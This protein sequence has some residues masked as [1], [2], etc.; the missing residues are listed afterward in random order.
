MRELFGNMLKLGAMPSDL[1]WVWRRRGDGHLAALDRAVGL[2]GGGSNGQAQRIG[3]RTA[4]WGG[5]RTC[6]GLTGAV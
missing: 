1:M 2:S 4:E 3:A 5:R 6:H